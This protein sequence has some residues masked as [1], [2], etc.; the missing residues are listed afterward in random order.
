LNSQKCVP[1]ARGGFTLIEVMVAMVLL[2]VGLLGLQA[3][4]IHATRATG[5]AEKNSRAAA[6]A[7][8]FMESTLQQIRAGSPAAQQCQTLPNGDQVSVAV[9]VA[10]GNEVVVTVRP[11][12]EAS[13]IYRIESYV[14]L[15]NGGIAPVGSPCA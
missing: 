7:T 10:G 15:P 3:L 13:P 5:A 6:L 8:S 14:F 1:G 2:A 4:G 11:A 12:G 9:T